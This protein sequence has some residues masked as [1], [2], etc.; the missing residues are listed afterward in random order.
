SLASHIRA[1]RRGAQ[2]LGLTLT[3]SLSAIQPL[4]VGEND[5]ALAVAQRLREQGCWVTAIRPPTVPA[6][7]ARL[8]LT[9]TAAHQPQ[10]IEQ[11]LEV[12]HAARQ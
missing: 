6:G 9:L 11:L 2:T 12:L 8:R 1:F 10:D 5:R 3:D 7:T 4:I